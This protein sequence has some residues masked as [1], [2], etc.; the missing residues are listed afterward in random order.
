MSLPHHTFLDPMDL[1]TGT[2]TYHFALDMVLMICIS[3][4]KHVTFLQEALRNNIISEVKQSL[5]LQEDGSEKL[6]L[7]DLSD[8]VF[9]DIG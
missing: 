5:V 2:L 3:T 1:H 7:K 6:K 9:Q 4:N 8:A